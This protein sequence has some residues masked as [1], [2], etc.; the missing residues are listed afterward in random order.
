MLVQFIRIFMKC[1]FLSIVTVGPVADPGFSIGGVHLL[2]GMDLR[3]GCFLVK[4]YAKMKELG[5]VRGACTGHT[6]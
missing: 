1:A 6:P 5:P 2:G 3:C 4:M